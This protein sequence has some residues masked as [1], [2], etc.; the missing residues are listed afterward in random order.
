MFPTTSLLSAV[1]LAL[2]VAASP[3]EV[4]DSAPTITLPFAL[5]LNMSGSTLPELDRIRATHLIQR[6]KQHDTVNLQDAN[7]TLPLEFSKR[8]S[9]FSVTNTAVTYVTSV[10]IG[11]PATSYTLLLDT[12]SSNTWVVSI[13]IR[14]L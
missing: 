8:A 12:G 4:R 14:F 10:K 3:V 5:H 6:G 2:S 1:L 11:S 9:S 7:A 13:F